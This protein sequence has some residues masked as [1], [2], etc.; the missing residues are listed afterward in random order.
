MTQDLF[1]DLPDLRTRWLTYLSP[2]RLGAGEGVHTPDRSAFQQDY[3]RVVFTSAFRRLKDKTQ[4]FPLAQSD[5]VRTRLTHSLEVSCVGRSLGA[6]VGRVIVERHALA[7]DVHASDFGAVV[8]AACLAHDIGNPPFGHAGEDAIREWFAGR[9]ELLAPLSAWE[10]ED[11]LRYEGNAQG[12][13]TLTRLQSPSNPGGLQL[14]AAILATF[15]KYPGTSL[16]AGRLNGRSAKKFGYF[17]EEAPLFAE[18][19]QLVGLSPR[20]GPD[21]QPV[22]G[23]WHRHPLAFLVEAA[24]DICYLVVDFEDGVK[25]GCLQLAEAEE[26]L[27][28]LAGG[29]DKATRLPRISDPKQRIE[30]LR[31][32]AIGHMVEAAAT[33]FLAQERE[34]IAGR[35]DEPLL[36]VSELAPAL[37]RVE[38]VSK[39]RIYQARQV[40]EVMAAGFEVIGGLLD[41]FV[42]AVVTPTGARHRTLR[43]LLPP[44]YLLPEGATPYQ[45]LLRVADYVAGMTD[46][47]AVSLYRRIKGIDLPG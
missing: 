39:E 4:V 25:Q 9:P 45:R 40:M 3:D 18:L 10:Q 24:D 22:A 14:T 35:F 30:Y 16:T 12:F 26:L 1:D 13:R 8:A 5:Y 36:D 6:A 43:T 38:E 7:P 17:R 41:A 47:F 27:L 29:P 34:I 32:K 20:L 11:L 19:A 28:A 37:Q 23:A 31:A 46:S 15:T 42:T 33:I 2:H 44:E 21:G